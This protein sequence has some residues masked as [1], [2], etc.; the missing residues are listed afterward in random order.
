ML[1]GHG[2]EVNGIGPYTDFGAPTAF[3]IKASLAQPRV[4]KAM[5]LFS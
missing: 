5:W 3:F 2:Q 4:G 1:R